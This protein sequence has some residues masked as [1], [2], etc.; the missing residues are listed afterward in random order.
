MPELG[1]KHECPSCSTKFYDLGKAEPICPK[2]GANVR[3]LAPVEQASASQAARRRRKTEVAAAPDELEEE[4]AEASEA[5]I[6]EED[7]DEIEDDG[8]EI[9]EI[10]ED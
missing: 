6:D 8:E 3:E 7:D 4:P 1:K 5:L 2:C 10:D 9:V